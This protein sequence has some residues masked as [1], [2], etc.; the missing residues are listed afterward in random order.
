MSPI[1]K[2]TA[3][4]ACGGLVAH[5]RRGKTLPSRPYPQNVFEKNVV[6]TEGSKTDISRPRAITGVLTPRKL[7]KTLSSAHKKKTAQ[8]QEDRRK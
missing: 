7:D 8:T 4:V 2:R 6:I 5:K 3:N 1:G